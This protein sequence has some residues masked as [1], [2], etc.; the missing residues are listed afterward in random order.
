VVELVLGTVS[1][2][3]KRPR[4]L[5]EL[6]NFWRRG[7]VQP[8]PGQPASSTSRGNELF[9]AQA[10]PHQRVVRLLLFPDLCMLLWLLTTSSEHHVSTLGMYPDPRMYIGQ[11]PATRQQASATRYCSPPKVPGG[12]Q[13]TN[14]S[15]RRAPIP[16]R[17]AGSVAAKKAIQKLQLLTTCVDPFGCISSQTNLLKIYHWFKQSLP[18]PALLSV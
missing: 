1:T 2:D 11:Y 9:C 14:V 17:C 3:L 15:F 4:K 8:T 12:M 13:G 10:A 5:S 7:S 6:W 16:S 18:S